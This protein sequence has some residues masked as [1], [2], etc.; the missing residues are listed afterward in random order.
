MLGVERGDASGVPLRQRRHAA[1][2]SEGQ[3]VSIIS[4]LLTGVIGIVSEPARCHYITTT[5]KTN[6]GL[7]VRGHDLQRIC[8]FEFSIALAS[9]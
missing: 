7:S 6:T 9:E 2:H 8:Y 3:T 4:V 1:R 5:L